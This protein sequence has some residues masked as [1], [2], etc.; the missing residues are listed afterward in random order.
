MTTHE[1]KAFPE[2]KRIAVAGF[3]GYKKHKVYTSVFSERGERINSYW[4][5]GTRDEFALVE[6][7]TLRRKALP[8]STHPY[9]DIAGRGLAN[10][11]DSFV[12]VDHVGNVTLKA[13]PP[14]FV[15][16]RAGTFCGKPSTA[17]ILFHPSDMPRY[18]PAAT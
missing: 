6:L 16:V 10:A 3:P 13:I 1:L 17:E 8:T 7:A 9:Y 2:L 5:R 15:L 14:G 4:D 12:T 18:L 11:E